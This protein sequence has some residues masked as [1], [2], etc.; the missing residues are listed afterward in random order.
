MQNGYVVKGTLD[1]SGV[2]RIPGRVPLPAGEVEISIRPLPAESP[3]K[4]S[5]WDV[6]QSCRF[7]RSEDELKTEL[8]ALR[9]EWER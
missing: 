6:V 5:V 1:E 2:L 7:G 9:D 4:H 8:K 3:Q